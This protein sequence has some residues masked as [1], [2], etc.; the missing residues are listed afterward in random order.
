MLQ[1]GYSGLL[2]LSAASFRHCRGSSDGHSQESKSVILVFLTAP[3]HID[4]F[5]MKPDA[6]EIRE[7][8]PIATNAFAHLPHLLARGR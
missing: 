7:F 5:D 1:V 4:T 2:G 6:P 8:Q 3:G